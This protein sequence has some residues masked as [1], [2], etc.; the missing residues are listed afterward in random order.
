MRKDGR[1]DKR[2]D[3]TKLIVAFSYF[4][5][6]PKYPCHSVHHA[7]N[8]LKS[9]DSNHVIIICFPGHI[10]SPVNHIS[11]AINKHNDGSRYG[12]TNHKYLC[13]FT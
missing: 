10:Q 8:M 12:Q 13:S 11:L 7:S 4:A 1:K 5:N 6:A 2:T 9:I 3:T